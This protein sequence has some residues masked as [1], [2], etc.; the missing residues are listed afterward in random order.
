LPPRLF[1]DG[2]SAVVAISTDNTAP[3][4]VIFPPDFTDTRGVVVAVAGLWG[5]FVVE[6]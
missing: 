5:S 3:L 1:D 2:E 4:R 6:G